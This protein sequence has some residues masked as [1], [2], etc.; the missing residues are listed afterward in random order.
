VRARCTSLPLRPL[1]NV[2]RP[3]R[4]SQDVWAFNWGFVAGRSQANYPWDSWQVQYTEEPAWFHDVLRLDGSAYDAAEHAYLRNPV[5]TFLVRNT[6]VVSMLVSLLVA[7]IFASV[8]CFWN[9]DTLFKAVP[10][11]ED[12]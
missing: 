6:M 12:P 3:L 10:K 9:R 11:D 2:H 1:L 5:N 4:R 8:A 7:S